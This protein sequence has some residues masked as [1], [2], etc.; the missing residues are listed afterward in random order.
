MIL[1]E[2]SDPLRVAAMFFSHLIYRPSSAR[3]FSASRVT[4]QPAV[5]MGYV[6]WTA[7]K[8]FER[9]PSEGNALAGLMGTVC[10]FGCSA[11]TRCLTSSIEEK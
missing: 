1:M 2:S 8:T 3:Q 11:T 10:R 7:S 9:T 4:M 5:L 6:T